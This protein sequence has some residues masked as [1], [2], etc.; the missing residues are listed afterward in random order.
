MQRGQQT[1]SVKGQ[2]QIFLAMQTLQSLL[3]LLECTVEAQT[4]T[5]NR[6][7]VGLGGVVGGPLL[8]RISLP[9][10]ITMHL[11]LRSPG[12][13]NWVIHFWIS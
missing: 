9:E 2:I 12:V 3:R 7:Q 11:V 1:V 10:Y 13:G 6:L 5:H 8:Y 4:H